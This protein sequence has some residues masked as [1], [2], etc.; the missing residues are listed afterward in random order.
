MP[1]V[2]LSSFNYTDT[3][4][5]DLHRI[6]FEVAGKSNTT[7]DKV[8]NMIWWTNKNFFWAYTDYQKRTDK[9]IICR[10]G[11]NCNEQAIVVRAL[12]SELNVK[13]RRTAEINI[14]PES[15]AQAKRC[16]K[17]MDEIGNRGS[18]FGYRHNDHVWIEFF[19]E[20]TQEWVPADPTI[21]LIGME[22]WLKSRIGFEPRINHAILATAEMLVPIAIFAR[23]PDGS[24]GENRSEYYLVQSFNKVY[25]NQLERLQAWKQWRESIE[26]IQ[27]K[28]KDAFEGKVNLHD[29]TDNIKQVKSIYEKLKDQFL[30]FQKRNK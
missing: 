16:K 30:A 11:G 20:E 24:I 18:V 15:E 4:H 2:N 14:Q 28:A 27:Y 12:L 17:R 13:T 1:S 10:Q 19:D 9:Q 23:N 22:N 3:A 25:K 8:R 26:F 6:A 7:F 29:Y 21:G 5:V